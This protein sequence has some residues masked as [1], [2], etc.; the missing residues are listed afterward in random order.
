MAAKKGTKRGGRKTVT[1]TLDEATLVLL[2]DA[3]EILSDVAAAFVT[4]VDDPAIRG[5]LQKKYKR[6]S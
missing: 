4:N 2:T 6:Q 1:I 5:R 3:L